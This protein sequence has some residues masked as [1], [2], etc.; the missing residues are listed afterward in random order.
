ME[1]L[2][3]IDTII[4]VISGIGAMI[5]FFCAKKEKEACLKIKNEINQKLSEQKNQQYNNINGNK[6]MVS[7]DNYDIKDVKNFDN[8]KYNR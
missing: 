7:N 5:M 8:R 1:F 6:N 4:S 3:N 2:E